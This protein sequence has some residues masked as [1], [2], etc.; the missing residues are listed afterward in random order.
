[1]KVLPDD[2]L[3]IDEIASILKVHRETVKWYI[4]TNKIP[5]IKLGYRTVRVK[6][7]DLQ[8]FIEA[9]SGDNYFNG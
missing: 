3:T 1:M 5:A 9:H 6:S 4:Q 8:N 2:L 7:I